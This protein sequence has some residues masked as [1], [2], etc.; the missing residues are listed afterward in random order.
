MA[1]Q[2]GPHVWRMLPWFLPPA[3][4]QADLVAADVISSFLAAAARPQRDQ[5][6]LQLLSLWSAQQT[7]SLHLLC[8]KQVQLKLVISRALVSAPLGTMLCAK[9]MQALH[10]PCPG[11]QLVPCR[12]AC[13]P[14]AEV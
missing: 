5:L 8:R 12:P 11:P 9:N 13:N 7:P 14:R 10:L 3:A 1:A 2:Q 4:S 6:V